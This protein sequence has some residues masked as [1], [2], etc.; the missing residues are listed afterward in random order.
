[1]IPHTGIPPNMLVAKYIRILLMR[2]SEHASLMTW[3]TSQKKRGISRSV[4]KVSCNTIRLWSRA[5]TMLINKEN[6]ISWPQRGNFMMARYL[7]GWRMATYRSWAIT[8]RRLFSKPT[9]TRM[10]QSWVRQP[11]YVML[12]FCVWMFTSIFGIVVVLKQMSVK[13]KL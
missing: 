11:V 10:K 8:A 13:D 7:S 9:K 6:R 12:W 3:T 1:M 5:S 2:V 4:Q